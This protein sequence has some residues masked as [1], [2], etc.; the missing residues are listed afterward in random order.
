MVM[1]TSILCVNLVSAAVNTTFNHGSLN[2]DLVIAFPFEEGSG[3]IS[4]DYTNNSANLTLYNLSSSI[5][6]TDGKFG[7]GLVFD[8]NKSTYG[9]ST[10]FADV[11][12]L[13]S[14]HERTVAVWLNFS[15]VFNGMINKPWGWGEWAGAEKVFELSIG[16]IGH[17][18]WSFSG[19]G[20]DLISDVAVN[21]NTWNL[22]VITYNGTDVGIHI[23]GTNIANKTLTLNTVNTTLIVGNNIARA[24]PFNGTLDELYIWNRTLNSS[25]ILDLWNNG[26]GLAYYPIETIVTVNSQTYN[27]T[28]TETAQEDFIVNITYN[29]SNWNSV[30]SKLNYN[31]TNYTGTQSG[32]GDTILF[33]RTLSIPSYSGLGATNSFHWIFTLTN[34]TGVETY[35]SSSNTQTV[36]GINFTGYCN[37]TQIPFINFT[38]NEAINPFPIKNATFKSSWRISTGISSTILNYSFENISELNHSFA[39]CFEDQDQS[40]IASATIEI[41]GTGYAKNFYFLTNATLTNT[42]TNIILYL[43]NDSDAT[44]TVLKVRDGAQNP[45]KNVYIS[46]QFYDIGTDTFKTIGMA[47]TSSEGED[48][49]YLNWYDSL[50]KFVLVL[51]G[52]TIKSTSPYKISETPQIFDIV[53]ASTYGFAKF[54]DFSWSLYYNDTTQNF[55]LTFVKPSGD[56]DQGCLRVIKRNVTG[57][58]LICETCES[59]SS[60]T[61]YCNIA[62]YGN[63]TFIGTFYA[64]GSLMWLDSI[65]EMVGAVSDVYDLIGNLDGTTM[66][67]ILAGVVM[68]VFLVGGA[69]LGVVG[70]LLGMLAVFAVGFQPLDVFTYM[71]IVIIGGVIVWI[72]NK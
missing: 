22:A 11:V 8:G 37:S 35:K 54:E 72:L 65:T 4:R 31:G 7:N 56:V 69:A 63:G 21:A 16:G 30:T 38:I 44:A 57:D 12:N 71:G 58:T 42:T 46:I 9:N 55:V 34:S 61:V 40:Y 66:A 53:P 13:S 52:I 43:L 5:W 68:S 59:S 19:F 15:N 60:A 24:S 1:L 47:K 25:E 14:N 67:I 2:N 29:S 20:A 48:L 10:R 62:G 50:Y 6:T 49:V 33:R 26:D 3:I 17:T 36:S 27:V 23:N 70:M 32:I 41:D 39:F 45:I 51:N 64:T 28:T 18:N